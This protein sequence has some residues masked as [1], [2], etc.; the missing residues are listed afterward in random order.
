MIFCCTMTRFMFHLHFPNQIK[1]NLKSLNQEL[2]LLESLSKHSI[3]YFT[4][5]F[6]VKVKMNLKGKRRETKKSNKV[7][8]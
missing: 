5:E 8:K 2:V 7:G 4:I 1:F 6:S 3:Q